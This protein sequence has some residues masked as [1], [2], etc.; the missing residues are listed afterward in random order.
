[1]GTSGANTLPP[2]V[3]RT[4]RPT[5]RAHK[6]KCSIVGAS[7][8]TT[9]S[10]TVPGVTPKRSANT[11]CVQ[12]ASC[13]ARSSCRTNANTSAR[14]CDSRPGSNPT[15]HL[16]LDYRH[17][18]PALTVPRLDKPLRLQSEQRAPSRIRRD[19]KPRGETRHGRQSHT[20]AK[21]TLLDLRRQLGGNLQR[22][23]RAALTWLAHIPA[24][25]GHRVDQTL[26]GELRERLT[27]RVA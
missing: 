14:A 25:R 21:P 18:V 20:R 16:R 7:R 27:Q 8:P 26:P 23:G 2:R 15:T 6:I 10:T 1:Y 13:R 24:P 3:T 9:Q 5:S 4:T 22:T 19:T 11:R 17:H 12:P